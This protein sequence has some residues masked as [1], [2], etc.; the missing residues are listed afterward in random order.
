[1]KTRKLHGDQKKYIE[2]IVGLFLLDVNPD[3]LGQPERDIVMY[4]Y[5][6][7][8]IAAN[9]TPVTIAIAVTTTEHELEDEWTIYLSPKEREAMNNSNTPFLI[10]V[11]DVKR[12]LLRFNWSTELQGPGKRVNGWIAY[13][14][15]LRENTYEE[16]QAL[17][18]EIL[19]LA[20]APRERALAPVHA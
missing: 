5:L 9:G 18:R 12:S 1:M 4:Q 3:F 2:A 6:A 17:R 15:P 13:R 19:E 11:A 16:R 8:F 14:F 10:V 7:T 20:K